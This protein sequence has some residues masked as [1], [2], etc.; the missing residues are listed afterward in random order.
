[1]YFRRNITVIIIEWLPPPGA[2]LFPQHDTS[3]NVCVRYARLRRVRFSN[4]EVTL[5][6]Q[7]P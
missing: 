3:G 6:C 1:M 4:S 7:Q 2:Y 5:Y